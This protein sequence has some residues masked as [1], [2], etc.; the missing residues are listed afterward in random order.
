MYS[1]C[2][3]AGLECRRDRVQMDTTNVAPG[4]IQYTTGVDCSRFRVLAVFPRSTGA[5]TLLFLDQV[6]KEML[7]PIE[8]IQTDR[9]REFLQ[10]QLRR[11]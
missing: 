11:K 2:K 10:R 7:F 6:I 9:G 3:D 4:T 1:E 5:N 8:R